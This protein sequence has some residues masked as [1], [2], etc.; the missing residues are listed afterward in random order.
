M[1]RTWIVVTDIEIRKKDLVFMISKVNTVYL[2]CSSGKWFPGRIK[3]EK[4]TSLRHKT[5]SSLREKA[6]HY[7]NNTQLPAFLW[8]APINTLTSAPGQLDT[9]G[10]RTRGPVDGL[11][12]NSWDII[13]MRIWFTTRSVLL[14]HNLDIVERYVTIIWQRNLAQIIYPDIGHLIFHYIIQ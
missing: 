4:K 8:A 12:H 3:R 5:W 9:T 2:L 10:V 13:V 14:V 7:N 1:I 6:Y 11:L